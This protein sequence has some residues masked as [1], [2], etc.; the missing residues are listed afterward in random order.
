MSKRWIC[1]I[2][3][4]KYQRFPYPGSGG[5]GGHYLRCSRCGRERDSSLQGPSGTMP[6]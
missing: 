2:I 4:H 3:G 6:V 5:A 1:R